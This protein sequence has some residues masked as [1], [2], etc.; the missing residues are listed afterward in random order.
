MRRTYITRIFFATISFFVTLY[1]F[2]S[3]T[4]SLLFNK[5]EVMEIMI[6]VISIMIAIIVTYLFSKLFSEKSVRIERK[7]SIDELAKKITLLRGIAF[8]FI[9]LHGFWETPNYNLK[10]IMDGKYSGLTYEHYLYGYGPDEYENWEIMNREIHGTPG[11]AYLALRELVDTKNSYEFYRDVVLRNYSLYEIANYDEFCNSIHYFLDRGD[12]SMFRFDRVN[13]YGL[14]NI[15]EI[16]FKLE[17]KRI[18]NYWDDLKNLFG[19]FEDKYFK[20]L[21]Y[22]TS[23]NSDTFPKIF[24]ISFLNVLAYLILL[25]MSVVI[26]IIKIDDYCQYTISLIIVSLFLANTID[27]ILIIFNSIQSELKIED[28]FTI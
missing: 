10:G 22:L 8:H 28:F 23:L 18:V 25:I 6:S 26:Y 20:R 11:K 3:F 21:S 4:D 9:G 14:N 15:D 17:G 2:F 13:S 24:K 5:K 12:Q 7:K 16:Y 27:L 1:S 19:N